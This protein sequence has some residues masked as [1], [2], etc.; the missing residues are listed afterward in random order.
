MVRVLLDRRD[1]YISALVDSIIQVTAHL[2]AGK[3]IVEM[4]RFLSTYENDLVVKSHGSVATA[5]KGNRFIQSCKFREKPLVLNDS[6]GVRIPVADP[7]VP[8]R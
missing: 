8:C 5:N 1:D 4:P 2:C 3:Q 7:S 6:R